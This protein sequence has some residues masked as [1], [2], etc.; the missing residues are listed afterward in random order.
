MT[1]IENVGTYLLSGEVLTIQAAFGV[2][3][4]SVLKTSGTVTVAGT[5]KLG[6]RNSD[7]I[8]LPD[9]NPLNISFDFSIDGY[10]IDATGGEAL[11]IAG[12]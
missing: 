8:T 4:I 2:R 12:K 9:A 1:N 7:V 3:N 10:I 11:V 5:M 6:I